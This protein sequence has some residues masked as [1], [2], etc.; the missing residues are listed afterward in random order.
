MTLGREYR[1]EAWL[2][3]QAAFDGG[4][5]AERGQRSRGVLGHETLI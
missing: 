3:L 5:R 4:S 2:A 1:V